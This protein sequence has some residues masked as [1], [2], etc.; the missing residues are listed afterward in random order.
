M[1]RHLAA[2]V[3]ILCSGA[4]AWAAEP[5]SDGS[6]QVAAGGSCQSFYSQCAARCANNKKGESQAKCAS[7]HCAPKLAACRKSGCWQEG[8]DYGGG[9]S[10]G[11][12]K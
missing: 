6:F 12:A 10:C 3:L 1:V 9:K 11:L 7:D 8:N 2:F 5:R 4:G